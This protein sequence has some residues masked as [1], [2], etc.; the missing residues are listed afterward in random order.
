ME[1][2]DI[3]TIYRRQA[4]CIFIMQTVELRY[5]DEES[6]DQN[7]SKMLLNPLGHRFISASLIDGS[8]FN[9]SVK[10]QKLS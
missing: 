1:G 10:M 8:G 3:W 7:H 2:W 5:S 6:L 9:L 4:I